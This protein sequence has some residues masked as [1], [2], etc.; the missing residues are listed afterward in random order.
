M[1][2]GITFTHTPPPAPRKRTSELKGGKK[3]PSPMDILPETAWPF[4]YWLPAGLLTMAGAPL[5][6]CILEA[7]RTTACCVWLAHHLNPVD[8]YAEANAPLLEGGHPAPCCCRYADCSQCPR[9]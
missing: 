5:W 2:Q 7:I 8:W 4:A 6:V 9:S 1:A 3:V